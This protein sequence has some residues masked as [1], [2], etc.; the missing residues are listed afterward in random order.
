M[1]AT[2]QTTAS[3][4]SAGKP[5]ELHHRDRLPARLQP[6]QV[7]QDLGHRVAADIGVLEH[8]AVARIVAQRC[9]G[10]RD[11]A[12]AMH[13]RRAVFELAHAL[14]D[15]PDEVLELIGDGRVDGEAGALG[16]DLAQAEAVGL[17]G[18][19]RQIHALGDGNVLGEDFELLVDR[20]PAAVDDVD[21]FLEVE[22]P[23][24]Q[25]E[26]LRVD[27]VGARA[28]AAG[29]FVVAVEQE[30]AHVGRGV[31]HRVEDHRDAARLADAGRA[32]HGEMLVE[33]VADRDAR[34]DGVVVMQRA[35]GRAVGVALVDQ[36]Q[37]VAGEHAAASPIA[38]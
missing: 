27:D 7:G 24:R 17:R 19:M 29:E 16:V 6:E 12:M 11:Q 34:G 13:P 26:V 28:E 3:T 22:Q 15:Q 38:G 35:D 1:R 23:E 10:A 20:R 25:L 18:A 21:Q 8:E 32:E 2:T 14:V 37:I 4:T 36:P 33:H 30:H 31:E 9:R 5:G